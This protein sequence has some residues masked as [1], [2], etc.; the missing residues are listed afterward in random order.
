MTPF[1]VSPMALAIVISSCPSTPIDGTEAPRLVRCTI[2][3]DEVKPNA[4]ASTA[5]FA[6][7]AIVFMSSMVATS[8]LAPRSP[9]T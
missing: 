1:P 3:L 2:V 7:A 5:S 6:N 4:P 9:M 8:R